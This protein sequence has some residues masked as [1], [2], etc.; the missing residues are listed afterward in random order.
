MA[1]SPSTGWGWYR[2]I[3]I[4][5]LSNISADYQLKIRLYENDNT[6]DNPSNAE[7][8]LN[9]LCAD[10]PNDI[11]FGTTS[12]PATATQL[13]QWIENEGADAIGGGSERATGYTCTNKIIHYGTGTDEKTHI[14]YVKYDTTHKVYVRTYNHATNTWDNEVYI[15]DGDNHVN[16]CLLVDSN[17]YLYCIL[18][19]HTGV[20]LRITRSTNPNDSSSWETIY[21]IEDGA[22]EP[23]YASAVIDNN[24]NIHIIYRK[25]LTTYYELEYAKTSASN[26]NVSWT[27]T[28]L[29]QDTTYIPSYHNSIT[30]D[31]NGYL[32]VGIHWWDSGASKGVKVS[33]A[34][35]TDGGITWKKSDD[36][37]YTLPITYATSE[38]VYSGVNTRLWNIEIDSTGNPVM[39]AWDDGVLKFFRWNGTSWDTTTINPPSGKR[40]GLSQ[41]RALGTNLYLVTSEMN[42]TAT[43]WSDSSNKLV[44]YYSTDN[45]ATWT[46]NDTIGKDS[47]PE[48][49][50]SVER[51]VGHNTLIDYKFLYT[52]GN[53]NGSTKIWF[54]GIDASQNFYNIFLPN[55][56]VD[57][58]V[59]L[60]SDGS[61]TIYIF[62]SNPSATRYSDGNAT[63]DFF[64]DFDT[65]DT[66]KWVMADGSQP[67]ILDSVATLNSPTQKMS[68]LSSTRKTP[69]LRAMARVKNYNTRFVGITSSTETTN[70]FV[71]DNAYFGDRPDNRFSVEVDDDNWIITGINVNDNIWKI[72]EITIDD[73]AKIYIDGELKITKTASDGNG[74]PTDPM[75]WYFYIYSGD[76]SPSVSI[77]WCFLAKYS[78]SPPTWSSYGT[79]TGA[80]TQYTVTLAES[81]SMAESMLKDTSM[82]KT[83]ILSIVDTKNFF[84]SKYLTSV[85]SLIDNITK[86]TTKAFSDAL[87]LADILQKST[88]ASRQDTITLADTVSI[89]QLLSKILTELMTLNET[90]TKTTG[91]TVLETATLQEQI[92]KLCSTTKIDSIT[93]NES[94]A[95]YI[96]KIL[97]EAAALSDALQKSISKSIKDAVSLLEDIKR[98][99]TIHKSDILNLI[100]TVSTLIA[101]ITI[102]QETISLQEAITKSTATTKTDT[103]NL[104]DILSILKALEIILSDSITISDEV[105]LSIVFLLPFALTI[106][107]SKLYELDM[108]LRKMYDVDVIMEA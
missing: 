20:S 4:S 63:F 75:S 12:D 78:S 70:P 3:D 42:D 79:W 39:V 99:V 104:T 88:F 61:D 44:F 73:T 6:K 76:S 93:L 97:Q 8:S 77:D 74:I 80:G 81:F 18:G 29:V 102:L 55:R 83:D 28:A 65:F 82:I 108:K 9:G 100:D 26:W 66:S 87:S 85:I 10:F 27:K 56:Y 69:P 5:D 30:I 25:K 13:A 67:T 101:Y 54:S 59:K 38:T 57:M 21:T 62:V 47:P 95:K 71:L 103:I 19:G 34:K 92:E 60:P 17:G 16:P 106:A 98:H 37:S 96:T 64:D 31:S 35:S 91:K 90:I 72:L 41:I 68:A 40:F 89:A 33:F 107:L 23:T 36:T 43:S 105:A 32:Y 46:R 15:G 94:I 24:D 22:Y 14:A 52:E 2:Q 1:L 7:L 49:D 48:W 86:S 11:R 45:G 58:W 84:T 53:V 51:F 50:P